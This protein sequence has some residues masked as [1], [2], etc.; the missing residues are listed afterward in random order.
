MLDLIL[1]LSVV[2]YI[3]FVSGKVS[4]EVSQSPVGELRID[5][6]GAL[7]VSDCPLSLT[8]IKE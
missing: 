4:A 2:V 3:H 8:N 5:G 7:G 1:D 6:I